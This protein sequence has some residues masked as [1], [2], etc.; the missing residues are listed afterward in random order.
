MFTRNRLPLMFTL[1]LSFCLVLPACSS[2]LP[3][4]RNVEQE[5]ILKKATETIDSIKTELEHL[6]DKM[7]EK[8][9]EIQEHIKKLDKVVSVAEEQLQKTIP[10][11]AAANTEGALDKTQKTVGTLAAFVNALAVVVPGA[12]TAAGVLGLVGTLLASL[13]AFATSRRLAAEKLA[14][15]KAEQSAASKGEALGAVVSAVE[16]LEQVPRDKLKAAVATAAGTRLTVVKGEISD[17][18]RELGLARAA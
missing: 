13:K 17:T 5:S 6:K 3:M 16:E 18:K 7:E 8:T 12:N 4:R 10:A 9:P 14:K 1:L 11:K 2:L 15:E